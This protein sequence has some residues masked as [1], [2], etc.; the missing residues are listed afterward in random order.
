MTKFD[1]T[2]AREHF[3]WLSMLMPMQQKRFKKIWKLFDRSNGFAIIWLLFYTNVHL[4]VVNHFN[5]AWNIP[6]ISKIHIFAQICLI[7]TW[8]NNVFHSNEAFLSTYLKLRIFRCTKLLLLLLL[9]AK[10]RQKCLL[11]IGS[12]LST[13]YFPIGNLCRRWYG[14][15][16]IYL[17]I[18]NIIRFNCI[19]CGSKNICSIHEFNNIAMILFGKSK[20]F[21]YQLWKPKFWWMLHA[22]IQIGD[23]VHVLFTIVSKFEPKLRWNTFTYEFIIGLCIYAC[24]MNCNP[25]CWLCFR[26]VNSY[27]NCKACSPIF[28]V[29]FGSTQ[30]N[31]QW[32]A[33]RKFCRMSCAFWVLVTS[34]KETITVWAQ[35]ASPKLNWFHSD[36]TINSCLFEFVIEQLEQKLCQSIEILSFFLLYPKLFSLLVLLLLFSYLKWFC[37]CFICRNPVMAPASGGADT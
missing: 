11:F 25:I 16:I 30:F 4:F 24:K 23:Q 1:R 28:M 8:N 5:L 21:I 33:S 29:T 13:K 10:H 32:S 12:N 27:I 34:K 6:H 14:M 35:I 2:R 19:G 36:W 9:A 37:V 18:P 3:I 31:F 26:Q 20:A 7:N 17:Y 22:S 15:Y